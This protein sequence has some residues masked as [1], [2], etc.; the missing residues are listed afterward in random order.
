MV[1]EV[2]GVLTITLVDL[3]LLANSSAQVNK[4]KGDMQDTIRL[5]HHHIA[6]LDAAARHDSCQ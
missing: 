5:R 2:D 1:A 6:R 3:A 4:L